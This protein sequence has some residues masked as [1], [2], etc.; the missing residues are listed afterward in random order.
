MTQSEIMKK[1]NSYVYFALTGEDFDP[2]QITNR[3]GVIP[4]SSWRK[5][6]KGKYK[7]NLENSGWKIS[8]KKGLE[9]LMLDRLVD[10]IIEKLFDRIEEINELKR[11]FNLE[12]VLEIVMYVD[13]NDE[14]STPS[15][16][17]GLKTLEFLYRTQ[18]TTD[19]D[20]YRFNSATT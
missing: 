1:G 10:E 4:T 11:Q 15:L 18:T 2:N 7:S 13:I 3:I 19:I 17:H 6:E 16:G 9:Y 5:G 12:S 8:T 20:I 14:Q